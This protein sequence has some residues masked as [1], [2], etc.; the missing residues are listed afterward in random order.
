M[1]A[2]GVVSYGAAAAAFLGLTLLLATSW[3]GRAQGVRLIAA[4]AMTALWAAGLAWQ[5]A[6]HALAPILVYTLEVLRGGAWLVVL[7][8]LAQGVLPRRLVLGGHLLWTGLLAAGWLL[9]IGQAGLLVDVGPSW[10]LAPGGLALALV[11]LV[12][13]EQVYRNSNAAGRHGF[14]FLALGLG[15]VFAYDLFMYSQAELLKGVSA[16]LW[17]VRGLLNALLVPFIAIAARRNPHWSLDVFVSRQV[18]VFSTAVMAIGIYLLV[19]A[20]GGYYVRQ[21]GGSW[22]VAANILFFAGALL[23][24][25]VIVLS[26]TVRRHLRVFVSKHFFRNKYDYRVEWLRFVETLSVGGEQDVRRTSVQ[27]IAQIFESPGG[28]MYTQ[29]EPGRPFQPVAAW[30]MRLD[31]LPD[32]LPVAPDHEMVTFLAARQWVIDLREYDETPE[33]YQNIELP[34]ALRALARGRVIAPLLQGEG[35]AGFVLL[36]EPPPP[37][38]LT[39]EDRDLLKTVGRHVA[40]ILAQYE[41]DRRLAESRQFEAYHRL[42]A[43]MMHDL[44][45]AVAQLQ[46][47][48]RNAEKHRHNPAFIDDALATIANAVERMNRLIEQLRDSNRRPAMAPVDLGA[49]LARV[50]ARCA[51]RQPMPRLA[52]ALPES[53]C[54]LADAERLAAAIEHVVRNA[55]DAT[56]AEGVITLGLAADAEHARLT[57]RDNGAGMSAEFLRER[58]FRPFDSTKGAR[59]MG[60]GAHQVREYIQGLGGGVEVQSSPG[61]GTQFEINLPVCGAA[62]REEGA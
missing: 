11:V 6:G 58:L 47:V 51:D 25:A 12:L 18:V 52:G 27:A 44:K 41:A 55:Q 30:P 26:G 3:Q 34:A 15:G 14:K 21:V 20:V 4:A 2:F 48:V 7:L 38:E 46:L 60:I 10:L 36:L 33:V 32:A 19:M 53:V 54:V 49:L 23:V 39:F 22:G 24:L 29:A 59:G 42:T 31:T 16:E 13:L 17:R 1:N 40:T 8:G 35:L 45:N 37:F 50:L 9:A 28:L 5:A 43:F 57:V 56:P 62:D 61:S